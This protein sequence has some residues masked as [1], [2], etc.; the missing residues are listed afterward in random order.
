M[1]AVP[2]KAMKASRYLSSL[3]E[4]NLIPE[5]LNS[6][7]NS[8]FSSLKKKNRLQTGTNVGNNTMFFNVVLSQ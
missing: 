2:G 4:K 5:C 6:E 1:I 7:Q 8:Q 3:K